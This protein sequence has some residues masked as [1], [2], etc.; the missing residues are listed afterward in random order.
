[1]KEKVPFCGAD[2]RSS[3]ASLEIDQVLYLKQLQEHKWQD[4][5]AGDKA[6][7]GRVPVAGCAVE[8]F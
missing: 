3:E 1:V 4:Q 8:K 7:F 5:E 6:E 2:C